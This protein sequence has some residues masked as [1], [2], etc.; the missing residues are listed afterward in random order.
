V[1]TSVSISRTVRG[2]AE[3]IWHAL[4]SGVAAWQA[5]RAEG[6]IELGGHLLLAW[7]ALGAEVDLDVIDVEEGRR[8]VLATGATRVTFEVGESSV[9]LTH[10]GLSPGDEVDGT[11]ASWKVALGLLDHYLAH[12]QGQDRKNAW[13]VQRAATTPAAAHVYFS[14][15]AALSTWL[16]RGGAVGAEGAPVTL[17]LA[18]GEQLT[19]TVLASEPGRDV[20]ISWRQ[21]GESALVFR[22]LPAPFSDTERLL[23]ATW[24]CW[25]IDPDGEI[26]ER[27]RH[28][29]ERLARILSNHAEA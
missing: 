18:W 23:V 10:S 1:D 19:G 12:H 16:T 22:T 24:S 11:R 29:V 13:V 15:E 6:T 4:T 2:S 25:G 9:R 3:S 21:R 20:A 5:D 26:A 14:D 28:G 27:L 7:P 17:D 8:L